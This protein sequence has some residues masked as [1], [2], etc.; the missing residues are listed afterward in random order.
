MSHQC[1]SALIKCIDFRLT[2]AIDKWMEEKGIMDDCD[3]IS[4]AG[5]SK[6]I[7]EDVDSADAKFILNQIELSVKLHGIK[8][9]YLVHHTDC[10][11]YGGHSAFENLETE[12]Q[13]YNSDMNKAKEVIN[14]KFPGLEVKS[15]LADIKDSEEVVLLEY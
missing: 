4:V 11:A 9:L 6:A 13:K 3:V 10:G 1:S 5:I 7:V 2:S 12:K 8:T 15:I 14:A